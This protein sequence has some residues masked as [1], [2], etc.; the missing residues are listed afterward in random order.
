MLEA[1]QIFD[2]QKVCYAAILSATATNC[3]VEGKYINCPPN[4]LI[5]RKIIVIVLLL[6]VFEAC[7]MQDK[8]SVFLWKYTTKG[9]LYGAGFKPV[10]TE[11]KSP[12][13]KEKHI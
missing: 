5:M 3:G 4:A 8:N 13:T 11:F 9:E 2:R 12:I 6:A 1:L 10:H 7:K